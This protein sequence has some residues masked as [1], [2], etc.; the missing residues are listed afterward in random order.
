M[1]KKKND[2]KA[3]TTLLLSLPD[4]HQLRFSKYKTV[5]ELWA[6]ILKTFGENEN[7]IHSL[8]DYSRPSHKGYQNT[9][10]LLDGNNV[11]PLRSDTILLVEN[12]FSFQGLRFADRNQ[13]LKAN[14]WLEC[15]PTG[16][17]FTW[18]DLTTPLGWNSKKVHVNW[19]HLEKK[20]TR[21]QLYTKVD[22]EIAY[23]GWRRH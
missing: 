12:E 5:R 4:E 2:V 14:N 6:A 17:I 22:E 3:R 16:S 18:E 7:P 19:A 21:L 15:L 9:I 10:D 1:Q 20:R 23:S 11:V 8:G 13:H